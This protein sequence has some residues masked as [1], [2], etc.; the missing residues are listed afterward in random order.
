MSYTNLTGGETVAGRPVTSGGERGC[1][2]RQK[3]A[4]YLAIPLVP[5]GSPIE[6]FLIDPPIVIDPE[7]LGI[8]AVGVSLLPHPEQDGSE[9]THIYDIV[10]REH[11]PTVGEFVAEARRMGIS[12]RI[13]ANTE[14]AKITADSRLLLLHAHADIANALEFPTDAACPCRT[15]GH[16]A[17]SYSDMC[18]RLWDEEPLA[19]A[20]HR[21]AI[22]A[23]FPACQIEVIH[24]PDA[25]THTKTIK[26]AQAAGIPVVE[27]AQ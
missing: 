6:H 24:D 5:G 20:R 9:T 14:F 22:F 23:S 13:A 17:P 11:Y 26:A 1:G 27:V 21:L 12:R 7:E 19:G 25:G 3:G 4:A 8:S 15:Q 10:G 18:V 2:E 16:S